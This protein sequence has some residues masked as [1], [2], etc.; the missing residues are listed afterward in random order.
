VQRTYAH[1]LENVIGFGELDVVVGHNL[2]A[3]A[4]GIANIE[5]IVDALDAEPV[6]CPLYGVAVID[7]KTEMALGVGWLA[8]AEGKLDK[9]ITEIDEGIVRAFATQ[10]EVKDCAVKLQRFVQVIDFED[11][12]IDPQRARFFVTILAHEI[13]PFF[14]RR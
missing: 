1:P 8:S 4:P 13:S 2:D 7:D 11:D 9:L 12:V 5:P 10:L 6:Q 3:I 14:D